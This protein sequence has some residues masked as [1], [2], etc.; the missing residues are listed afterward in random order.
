MRPR[1]VREASSDEGSAVAEFVIAGAFVV[2]LLLSVVQ[3]ALA[4]HVRTVAIDAASEGARLGARSGM[5]LDDARERA[6]D[7]LAESLSTAY[8]RDVAARTVVRDGA[9]LV[10]VR[11][12]APLPVIALF[13]P[14][15]R[16]SVT[17]HALVEPS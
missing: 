11:V 7:L 10:E 14:P 16:L 1:L 8:A 4:L 12:D 3:L 17:G 15:S 2:L 13:G 5:T 6:R 9:T